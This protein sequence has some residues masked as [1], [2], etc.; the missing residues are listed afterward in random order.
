MYAQYCVVWSP[1]LKQDIDRIEKSTKAV[2]QAATKPKTLSHFS[3]N[4]RYRLSVLDLPTLELRRLHV[5]LIWCYKIVFNLVCLN[6]DDLFEYCPVSIVRG[7][8]YR[9]YKKRCNSNVRKKLFF[10]QS[11]MRGILCHLL[12]ILVPYIVL[13]AL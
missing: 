10:Q 4:Y 2:H 13:S 6:F 1:H 11:L 7:H 3:Y 5:D 12:L 9:L 8:P